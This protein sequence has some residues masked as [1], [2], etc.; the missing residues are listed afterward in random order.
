MSYASQKIKAGK[1]PVE[2]LE[3]DVRACSLTY[4]QSPCTASGS[5]GTECFN[6]Y[7]TCQDQGNYANV[8]KTFRFSSIPLDG[9]Q[10]AGETPTFPTLMGISTSPTVLTPAKGFGIRSKVTINLMDM[11]W[12][13]VG[14]DKYRANRT[15]NPLEQGSFWSKFMARWPFYE[16]NEVRIKTG[17]LADD[18]SYDAS[19]FITRTFFLDTISGPDKSGRVTIVAKDILKFADGEKSNIPEQSQATLTLD[20]TAGQTTFDITDPENQISNG[21]YIRVDEETML[22]TNKSGG[23]LTV[24]RAAMPSTYTGT[25]T[26]EDHSEGSTVQHCHFFNQAQVDDILYYLLNTGAGIPSSYLPQSEWQ[27]TIDFG[28]ENYLFTAL[29]TEPTPVKD[30]VKEL[31]EHSILVWYDEREQ[32]V[33]MD[34]IMWRAIDYGPFDDDSNIIADSVSVARDDKSRFSQAWLHY[35]IRTPVSEMDE[36]KNYAAVKLTADLDAE[37]VNEYDQAKI[38]KIYSR[39]LPLDKQ[40]VASEIANRLVNYYRDTKNAITFSFEPKDD[41]AWT[42]DRVEL[43]TRLIQDQFGATALREYRIIQVKEV[44]SKKGVRYDYKAHS[45]GGIYEGSVSR[46]G[47]VTPN[48]IGDYPSETLENKSRYAFIAYDDRGDGKE[49]FPTSDQPYRIL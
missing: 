43:A 40:N 22:I 46:Y 19:N 33:K 32:E 41:S 10:S 17:Y 12:S 18:G 21:D 35:G 5:A 45:T 7:A 26:A 8:T 14:I 11:P 44:F 38:K 31:T 25:M 48:S 27:E 9:L 2:I 20:I 15:Y 13:D 24:T 30:L 49:G 42:G 36:L 3:I 37:G 4:G 47:V 23:T 39:W 34:S 28:L 29:I 1:E 16:N 6:S